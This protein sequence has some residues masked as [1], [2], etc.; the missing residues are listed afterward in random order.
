MVRRRFL[1]LSLAALAMLGVRPCIAAPLTLT[2]NVEADFNPLNPD[3]QKTAISTDPTSIGVAS[4]ISG[5]G[6]VSGWAIQNIWT[7][8]D[9]STDS[10]QVGIQTFKN[11]Q[12][13]SAI[14][15][16]SD[17]NGNPGTAAAATTAAGGIDPAGFGDGKSFA[18]AFSAANPG[19]GGTPSLI[20]GIPLDKGHLGPGIDGFT[21]S[22]FKNVNGGLNSKFGASYGSGAGS[23]AYNPSAAHPEAE[24]TINNFSKISGIDPTKGIWMSAYAG[25]GTDVIAGEVSTGWIKIPAF[26]AETPEPATWLAWSAIITGAATLRL[27]RKR[28]GS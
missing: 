17:G 12:G 27:R 5:A 18:V 2:G 13:Q 23:L 10:L 16:D 19:S 24:F 11:S 28:V 8:Y 22:Q 14:F 9:S 7:Y 1:I 3:V 25:S 6:L 20:A 4:S 21:I 15:G 26:A